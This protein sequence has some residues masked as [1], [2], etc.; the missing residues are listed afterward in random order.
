MMRKHWTPEDLQVITVLHSVLC[1]L[2]ALRLQ[3][4]EFLESYESRNEFQQFTYIPSVHTVIH[5][6]YFEQLGVNWFHWLSPPSHFVRNPHLNWHDSSNPFHIVFLDHFEQRYYTSHALNAKF[7][8]QLQT[9]FVRG[10]RLRLCQ[11]GLKSNAV[12]QPMWGQKCLVMLLAFT[13]SLFTVICQLS[14]CGLKPSLDQH[15]D[16]KAHEN[17]KWW[18]L[19]IRRGCTV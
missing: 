2:S 10:A 9:E 12:T 17:L 1:T 19:I 15:K 14:L 13:I 7:E 16:R 6:V 5:H 18:Y 8:N 3:F 11:S 4:H